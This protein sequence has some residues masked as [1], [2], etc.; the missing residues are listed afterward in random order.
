MAQ[1]ESYCSNRVNMILPGHPFHALLCAIALAVLPV[2]AQIPVNAPITCT[3]NGGFPRQV[4]AEGVTE[5][6]GDVVLVCKGEVP[7]PAGHERAGQG[8]GGE[9][10]GGELGDAD[11]RDADVNANA[12]AGPRTLVV[13]AGG[14]NL[15][16]PLAIK[17]GT[18]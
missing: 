16:L 2:G 15:T 14:Q 18:Y 10:R 7:T 17:V 1:A 9:R 13:T 5:L 8:A 11:Q 4:R 12:V 6:L 3:A